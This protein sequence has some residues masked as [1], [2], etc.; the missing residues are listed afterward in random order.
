MPSIAF[1]L[2]APMQSWGASSRFQYRESDPFPSKSGIIGLIAAALGTDKHAPDEAERLAPL[3]A[4]HFTAIR[5][6]KANDVTRFTDFHTIGGGYDKKRSAAEK[7]S[8]PRKASG[9]PFGTVITRR[10]YLTDA[11]FIAILT[12]G[13][14]AQLT[15]IQSALLDPV[16]GVWFGRKTC[17]PAAP[18]SPVIAPSPRAALADLLQKLGR[19]VAEIETLE[20]VTEAD[21]SGAWFPMDQPIA[22][23]QHHGAVPEPYLSR[24][25]RRLCPGDLA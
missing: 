11:A 17:I 10:S 18:L 19:D 7:M 22:F 4:L 24:P 6:P 15:Q 8:I 3:A 23:G 21:G 14:G 9:A 5:L 25:V 20:G 12:G 2:D 16:W 1:H 13:D